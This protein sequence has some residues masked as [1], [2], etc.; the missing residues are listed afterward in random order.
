MLLE[1]A[2]RAQEENIQMHP[3]GERKATYKY[4][5]MCIKGYENVNRLERKKIYV[6]C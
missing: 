1:C 3:T 5:L 6:V 4:Y 2:M